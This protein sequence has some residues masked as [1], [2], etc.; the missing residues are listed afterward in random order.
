MF[1]S[2]LS[3]FKYIGRRRKVSNHT[4]I[5]LKMGMMEITVQQKIVKHGRA[6]WLV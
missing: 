4:C 2:L 3:Y 5:P 6:K 1:T